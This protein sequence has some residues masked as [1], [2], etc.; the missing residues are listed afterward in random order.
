PDGHPY[1]KTIALT[2]I[3]WNEKTQA[4][5]DQYAPLGFEFDNMNTLYGEVVQTER[6]VISN[7]PAHDPRSGGLPEGH[8]PLK[9][10]L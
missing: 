5:Y 3:S 7:D 8:P 1:I 6:P 10:F 9:S 4:L 2:N